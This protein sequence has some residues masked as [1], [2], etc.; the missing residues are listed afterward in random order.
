MRILLVDDDLFAAE[1]ASVFLEMDGY[2]V[3]IVESAISALA[4]LDSDKTLDL[5]I[6]DLHMPEISGLDLL[7]LLRAQ[8]W[9]K[10]FILL[11]ANEVT[12]SDVPYD[13]WVK[14]DENLAEKLGAAV[15]ALLQPAT[16]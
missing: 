10:P 2:E 14:K 5:V 7:A 4:C 12:A 1:L 9:S 16:E 8:G 3:V 13:R 11:S 6:S 15:N